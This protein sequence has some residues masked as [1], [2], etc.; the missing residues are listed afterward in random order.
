M[1]IEAS[2]VPVNAISLLLFSFNVL[3]WHDLYDFK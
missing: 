3:V 1:E 2:G